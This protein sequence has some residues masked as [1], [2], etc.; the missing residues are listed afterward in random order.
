MRRD[1]AIFLL[2]ATYGLRACEVVT[3][4]ID[5]GPTAL[6]VSMTRSI[7]HPLRTP[8]AAAVSS[9][10]ERA[11]V[12]PAGQQQDAARAERLR[13]LADLDRREPMLIEQTLDKL[14]AMKLGAMADAFQQQLQTD[15]AATLGFEERFGLAC[16]FVERACRRGFTAR[17]LRMPRLLHELAVGGARPHPRSTTWSPT[18]TR[19]S[20]RPSTKPCATAPASARSPSSSSSAGTAT[21]RSR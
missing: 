5:D 15:E 12:S 3:L 1:Y 2:M 4:T 21:R 6:I 17:Y 19:F 9:A 11:D 16:A 14:N 20:S 10:D 13:R 18:G 7:C 8:L